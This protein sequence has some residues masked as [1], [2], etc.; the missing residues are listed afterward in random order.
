MTTFLAAWNMQIVSR[1]LLPALLLASLVGP[2]WVWAKLE[3][4]LLAA[5]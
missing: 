1:H 4:L 3:F 2:A 5:D